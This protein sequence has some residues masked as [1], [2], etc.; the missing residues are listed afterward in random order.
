MLRHAIIYS[1]D[2]MKMVLP[3]MLILFS[4]ICSLNKIY[5]PSALY[6]FIFLYVMFSASIMNLL[7]YSLYDNKYKWNVDYRENNIKLSKLIKAEYNQENSVIGQNFS[8]RGYSNLLFNRGMYE[9]K[10]LESLKLHALK[11]NKTF[12]IMLLCEQKPWDMYKYTGAI[13]YNMKTEKTHEM[14]V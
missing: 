13:I 8:V 2:R 14:K 3:L 6:K 5:K 4:F 7:H 12:V 11:Q 9:G 1:F 10:N